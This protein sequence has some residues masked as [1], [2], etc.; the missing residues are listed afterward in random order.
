MQLLEVP[1]PLD[2]TPRPSLLARGRRGALGT[3]PVVQTG[4]GDER[5]SKMA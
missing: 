1:P 3:P 5:F 2:P 4:V